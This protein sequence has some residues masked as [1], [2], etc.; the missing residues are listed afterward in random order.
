MTARL[1]PLLTPEDVA[2]LLQISVRTVYAQSHRLGGFYPVGIRALRFR[3]EVINAIMEGSQE[4]EISLSV[5][6][7]GASLQQDWLW[8]PEGRPSGHGEAP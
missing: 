3:R 8:H 1:V 5:P 7:P 2:R 6:V 4:R